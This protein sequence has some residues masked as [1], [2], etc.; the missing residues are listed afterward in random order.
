MFDKALK[1]IASDFQCNA[2]HPEKRTTLLV[3]A[4]ASGMCRPLDEESKCLELIKALTDRGASW[5]QACKSSCQDV[6]WKTADPKNSKLVVNYGTHT[7]IS[8]VQAW[9]RELDEKKG[10]KD[11]VSYLHKVLDICLLESQPSRN[12]LA[13]DEDIVSKLRRS[14]VLCLFRGR[15]PKYEWGKQK[16]RSTPL[17]LSKLFLIPTWIVHH[18]SYTGM[19]RLRCLYLPHISPYANVF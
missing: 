19:I 13:I 16:Q 14:Q 9:L 8:F 15:I 17:G 7:A 4:A 10:W 2:L 1:C 11:E 18:Y 5:T 3:E 6:A 12:K